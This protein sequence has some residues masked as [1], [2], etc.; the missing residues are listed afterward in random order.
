MQDDLF[1]NS[2]QGISYASG[3]SGNTF[4]SK[5][6]SLLERR[7][8]L[9]TTKRL[10]PVILQSSSR[11]TVFYYLS[12]LLDRGAVQFVWSVSRLLNSV[13]NTH[14][15]KRFRVKSFRK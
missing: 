10:D 3:M 15:S 4:D 9:T 2:E 11:L 1:S 13:K 5:V 12:G 14:I 6:H 8:M 7:T